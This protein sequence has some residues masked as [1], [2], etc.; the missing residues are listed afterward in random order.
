MGFEISRKMSAFLLSTVFACGLAACSQNLEVK[1]HA[2]CTPENQSTHWIGSWASSQQIPEP[3]N[4]LSDDILTKAS[5]RQ[6]VRLSFGGTRLRVRI[7]NQYGTAPLRVEDMRIAR[8]SDP[9]TSSIVQNTSHT[10][11]FLGETI[12][13]LPAGAIYTSDPIDFSVKALDHLVVSMYLPKAPQRQTSHPGSRATSYVVS[14]KHTNDLEFITPHTENH[15]YQLSDIEVEAPTSKS[16]IVIVGDSITD[17][18][19]TKPNTDTRWPDFLMARLQSHPT[20]ANQYSILNHGIGGN[21]MLRNGLGP[22]V[23]ARYDENVLDQ[24]GAKYLL[25]LEGVN[26]IGGL[27]RTPNAQQSDY[28]ELVKNMKIAYSQ[29]ANTARDHKI[30]PIGGTIMPFGESG[31]YHPN[32]IAEQARLDI[33]TWIRTSNTFDSI[34]DFDAFMKDPENPF[35]LN[36]AYDS[37]DHLHPSIPGYKAMADQIPLELFENNDTKTTCRKPE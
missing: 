34:V 19:G 31:F 33:N 23:V 15:W 9:H 21:N 28:D 2:N 4:T 14:G 13:T 7:S 27:A 12:I 30:I 25:L 16:A 32:A 11:T 17:G 29:V 5:L 36:P 37:G 3:R 24:K 1:T 35:M 6:V 22:N 26:D 20:L 8:S 18:Y 10:L